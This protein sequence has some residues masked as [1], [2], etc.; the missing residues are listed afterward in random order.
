MKGAEKPL[1]CHAIGRAV[2]WAQ[3]VCVLDDR[4]GRRSSARCFRPRATSVAS[5]GGEMKRIAGC[6]FGLLLYFTVGSAAPKAPADCPADAGA[7][8]SAAC[9]C[10]AK[11]NGQSWGN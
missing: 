4:P 1:E 7:A 10:D 5:R 9:P 2:R 8:I 3:G 6:L 11:G